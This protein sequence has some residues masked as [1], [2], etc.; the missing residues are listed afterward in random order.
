[1]LGALRPRRQPGS[2][3]EGSNAGAVRG[4]GRPDPK[5]LAGSFLPPPA[6]AGTDSVAVRYFGGSLVRRLKRNEIK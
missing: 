4:G 6:D 2:L 5:A 3:A 1:M